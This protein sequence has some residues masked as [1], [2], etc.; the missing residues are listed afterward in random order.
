MREQTNPYPLRGLPLYFSSSA[1]RAM[2]RCRLATG[3]KKTW[4]MIICA[5]VI[6]P[7]R[8]AATP[9]I[10]SMRK[11]QRE[12]RLLSFCMPFYPKKSIA[13]VW[14]LRHMV[15]QCSPLYIYAVWVWNSW[16]MTSY[17]YHNWGFFLLYHTTLAVAPL[18]RRAMYTPA[19]SVY[20]TLCTLFATRTMYAPC[21]I[22]KV[23]PASV[24]IP[25][26]TS[27]PSK[28]YT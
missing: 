20:M 15:G 28:V 12:K 11:T 22:C 18:L 10:F 13:P 19:G 7:P 1:R 9:T 14:L 26:S 2:V 23:T 8:L 24:T 4:R 5:C 27:L 17:S 16:H 3:V 21:G 6:Q 25:W